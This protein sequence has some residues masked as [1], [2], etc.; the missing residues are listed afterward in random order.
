MRISIA[1]LGLLVA[2]GGDD[3][4][5]TTI[6]AP[7]GDPDAPIAVDATEVDAPLGI[8]APPA[9]LVLTST[10]FTEGGVIPDIFSCQGANVSPPL[11]WTGGPTAPGYAVVLTDLSN[12]LIHSIIWDIPGT[13]MDL[14]Q[15]VDKVAEPPDVPGAKQPLAYDNST[16][17]YLGPCPGSQHTYEFAVYAVDTN[18]LPNVTLSSQRTLVRTTIENHRMTF[19]ILTGTFIP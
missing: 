5:S 8:D 16:R 15:D 10:G 3:G 12:N 11:A 19:A 6:D 4:G 17:G 13:R 18:P 9:A 1:A 2:C 14:P 7:S